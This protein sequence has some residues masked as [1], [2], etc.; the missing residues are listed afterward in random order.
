MGTHDNQH[1]VNHYEG[2]R[3]NH[4]RR[5]HQLKHN[6]QLRHFALQF[7]HSHSDAIVV[8]RNAFH[9]IV[10]LTTSG[11]HVRHIESSQDDAV[12]GLFGCS[13]R[14]TENKVY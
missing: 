10:V 7:I 4:R 5:L 1:V 9:E 6:I 13:S 12:A 8:F 2:G 11:Y 3:A 14:P